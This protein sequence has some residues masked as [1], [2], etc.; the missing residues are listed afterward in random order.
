MYTLNG[1]PFQ[2]DGITLDTSTYF[3]CEAYKLQTCGGGGGGCKSI[4]VLFEMTC[5]FF[6]PVFDLLLFNSQSNCAGTMF[7]LNHLHLKKLEILRKVLYY[8]KC[9]KIGLTPASQVQN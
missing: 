3:Y 2:L 9:D 1:F 5:H 6:R 4:S 7:G 8:L